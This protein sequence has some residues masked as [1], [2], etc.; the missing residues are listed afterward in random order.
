MVGIRAQAV[1]EALLVGIRAQ[2][3]AEALLVGIVA[4][5]VV[6]AHLVGIGA[7]VAA[8]AHLVGIAVAWLHF[9]F[10]YNICTCSCFNYARAYIEPL[11]RVENKIY[12]EKVSL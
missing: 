7:P 2:A 10:I 6:E 1:A 8:E 11:K 12:R 3:V 4:H 9:T 5:A